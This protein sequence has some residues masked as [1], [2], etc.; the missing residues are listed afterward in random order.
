MTVPIIF[1]SLR[2]GQLIYISGFTGTPANNGTATIV[3]ST[4][5][6]IVIS[7]ITFVNDAA[8]ESV[9]IASSGGFTDYL[10]HAWLNRMFRNQTAIP[11]PATYVAL[12]TAVIEDNDVAIGDVTENTGTGYARVQVNPN[13]GASPTWTVAA[14]GAIE[15]VQAITFPPPTATWVQSPVCFSSTAPVARVMSWVMIT[16]RS[17]PKRPSRAIPCNFPSA[18]LICKFSDNMV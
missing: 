14:A 15:N 11:K 10:V 2:C 6:T 13:G 3:S 7:G 4:S 5:S 1:R 16:S 18:G 12:S 8:G 17:K 9:R